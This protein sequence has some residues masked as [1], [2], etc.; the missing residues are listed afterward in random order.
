MKNRLH[1]K[2]WSNEEIANAERALAK[3]EAAKD[4]HLRRLESSMFWFILSIGILGTMLFA[5]VLIPILLVSNNAWAYLFTAFFGLVLGTI[6][7]V[8]VK[9]L[10]WFEQ[11]HHVSVSMLVPIVALFNFFIIVKKANEMSIES[12]IG[13]LHNPLAVGTVY[14]VSFVI[15]YIIILQLKNKGR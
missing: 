11:H 10:H 15:P 5:L 3:A 2:G 1:L 9:D 14:L 4:P 6:I 13:S 8:T 12:G 7:A